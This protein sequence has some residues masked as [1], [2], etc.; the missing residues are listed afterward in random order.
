VPGD[1]DPIRVEVANIPIE[2]CIACGEEFTGPKA[3]QVK[4]EAICR[5]LGLLVPDEI[6]RLRERLGLTQAE[7]SRL[8]GIGEATVSRWERGRLLQ[9][10]AMDRYLR[11]L[12]TDS[13]NMELLRRLHHGKEP[14]NHVGLEGGRSE[15]PIDSAHRPS[16]EGADENPLVQNAG[17]SSAPL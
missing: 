10:R 9:N 5:A 11:L 15:S 6:R 1:G 12:G 8:T 13:K 4:H 2:R 14:T 3:A 16:H 17:R 7:F